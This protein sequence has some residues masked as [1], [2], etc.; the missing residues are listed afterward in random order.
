MRFL[1]RLGRIVTAERVVWFLAVSVAAVVFF[2]LGRAYPQPVEP[3]LPEKTTSSAAAEE[4]EPAVTTEPTEPL[5]FS[6]TVSAASTTLTAPRTS[7]EAKVTNP[8]SSLP[9]STTRS[10]TGE[11]GGLLNLNTATK[12]QLMVINGIGESFADR[13][14]EY[15]ESH[16]GFQSVEE[17][18][19]ISG[20]GEKHYNKWSVYFTVN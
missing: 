16:G 7:A 5:E 9:A 10:N 4:S 11:R 1:Q 18:R 2:Q 3:H 19:N 12:E 14:I 8:T 17:L 13:I 20:I 6:G 15:R